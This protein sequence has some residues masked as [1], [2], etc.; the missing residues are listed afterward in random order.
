MGVANRERQPLIVVAFLMSK[1]FAPTAICGMELRN[2][3]VKSGTQENMAT[4]D[5]LP[6]AVTRRF[7]GEIARGGCG[8]IVTGLAYVSKVG[9]SYVR[10]HGAHTEQAVEAWQEVLDEVHAAGGKIALQI[11]HGGRQVDTKGLPKKRTLAPSAVPVLASFSLP[12]AMT[13]QEIWQTID[14]FAQ[15]ALRAKSVGFDAVQIHAAHGFLISGF[16]SPITNWR[17]DGWGGDPDRR[18][19]FLEETYRAIRNAV[20]DDFPVLCKIAVDDF[21][22]IGLTPEEGFPA[23]QRM[24]ELGVD[25]IEI[26]GGHQELVL[27]WIQ[28][29]SMAELISRDSSLL[30]RWFYRIML[31]L[32]Q[33][34]PPFREAYFLPYAKQLKPRLDVPLMLVGGN[35]DYDQVEQA[36]QDGHADFI[37]MAR[38]LVREPD[39]PI[40]WQSGAQHRAR[41][42][43]CNRC[44]GEVQLG[45]VLKCYQ[46]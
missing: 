7:Y 1:L 2:R 14:D 37:L 46:I 28:G 13:E 41:C 22:K 8:L 27:W 42:V 9:Q 23:A 39:L 25:A 12:R 16:L 21:M 19:R 29:D 33:P 35:R 6:S 15:A 18:R 36:L 26:S 10:Q 24:A 5:G 30:E 43:S 40:R 38:P 17:R 20:G 45:N 32:L 34:K 3:I 11:A 31:S 4:P 44:A